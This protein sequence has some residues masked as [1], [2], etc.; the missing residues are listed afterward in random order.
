MS[1]NETELFDL[2]EYSYHQFSSIN[3]ITCSVLILT[4]LSNILMTSS[5]N[6]KINNI[7]QKINSVFNPP[8]YKI[9]I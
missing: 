1:Y 8:E 4:S 3:F 2:M 6:K 5:L 9:N 7:N